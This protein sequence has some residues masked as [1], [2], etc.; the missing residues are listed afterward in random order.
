MK[1]EFK[2]EDIS[3]EVKSAPLIL[4]DDSGKTYVY[5]TGNSPQGLLYVYHAEKLK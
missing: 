4:C 1:I 2:T 5:F 3:G